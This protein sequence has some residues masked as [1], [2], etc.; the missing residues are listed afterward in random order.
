MVPMEIL[1]IT[2]DCIRLDVFSTEE[3]LD[4][5]LIEVFKITR[6]LGKQIERA[7]IPKTESPKKVQERV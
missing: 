5:D 7:Y 6:N 1:V 4:R 3:M 2:K